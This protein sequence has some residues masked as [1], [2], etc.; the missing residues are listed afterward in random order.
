MSNVL[1]PSQLSGQSNMHRTDDISNLF[2]RF[3]ASADSYL[4]FD[5]HFDYKEK[6]LALLSAVADEPIAQPVVEAVVE[7]PLEAE[8][9][10][11]AVV[12]K[13]LTPATAAASGDLPNTPAPL[14][15]L[16]AE[17]ALARQAE[18]RARN[19]E[20]LRQALPQGRP[21]KCKAH[22]IALVSN[23][24]GVGKTTISAAM[25]STLHLPGGRT[26]AIDLDPQNALQYHLGVEPDMA[27]MGSASLTGKNW[28]EVLLACGA[29]SL[30]LP[31]GV[32]KGSERRTLEQY[33]VND[34]HWL[35]RQLARMT[36]EEN[37]VIILDTPPGQ[38][39]YLEQALQ[40]A[41]QI[42]VVTTADAASFLTLDQ[43]EKSLAAPDARTQL[44]TFS[45]VINQFDAGRE[46]SRDML[47]VLK[48]RLGEQLLGVISLDHAL[49]ESLAYGRNPLGA[50]DLSPACDDLMLLSEQ[51]KTRLET[52]GTADIYAS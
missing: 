15:R 30:L 10:K 51:L 31:Y 36:L 33:L 25:A 13:S 45:Y 26:V 46:F 19:D 8:P 3:G 35:A 16:L 20:A 28:G 6:P 43:M 17:V 11:L 49:G 7:E 32:L 44:S 2:N 39:V 21:A 52:A 48:R 12:V 40:V 50:A 1:T 23:K 18:A 4:E 9:L 38:N 27:G 5:S 29:H 22:V 34:R 37:D 42:V 41:D 24:G 14:G 47:E